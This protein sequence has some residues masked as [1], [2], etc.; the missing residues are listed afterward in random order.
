[1]TIKYLLMADGAF[2]AGDTETR[3][4]VYAH[5]T[6]VHAHCAKRDPERTAERMLDEQRERDAR[7]WARLEPCIS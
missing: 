5:A 4:T 3:V 1:M 6:S 2:V 7:N